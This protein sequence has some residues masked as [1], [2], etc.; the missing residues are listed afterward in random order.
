MGK[1]FSAEG[2]ACAKTRGKESKK[3]LL[4]SGR[5]LDVGKGEVEKEEEELG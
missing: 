1:G 3:P 2:T 5:K 4:H